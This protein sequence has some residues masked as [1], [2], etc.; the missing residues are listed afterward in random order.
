MGAA[1]YNPLDTH[2]FYLHQSWRP[3]PDCIALK[4]CHLPLFAQ[5]CRGFAGLVGVNGTRQ[6]VRGLGAL[7]GVVGVL[8]FPAAPTGV[9]SLGKPCEARAG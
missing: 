6:L 3:V 7:A 8:E 2:A 1:G 4:A 9:R 5:V